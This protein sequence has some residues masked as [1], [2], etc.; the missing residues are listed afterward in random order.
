MAKPSRRRTR[1]SVFLGRNVGTRIP[2]R[3]FKVFCEGE[4][5]ETDYVKALKREPSIHDNTSIQ[6]EIDPDSLGSSPLTLVRAAVKALA[7]ETEVDEVWC[8]FDVEWPKNHPHLKEARS[9]A[10]DHGVNVA[11]SNPSFELWL[12]LHFQDQTAW[13]TTSE[14]TRLRRVL[15]ASTGKGVNWATY[16]PLRAEAD[17][18]ARYLDR[19][20]RRGH[21]AFPEGQ[22]VIGYVPIPGVNRRNAL[23]T[24]H[25]GPVRI[26]NSDPLPARRLPACPERSGRRLSMT[27]GETEAPGGHRRAE[28]IRFTSFGSARPE[29]AL[30]TWPTRK[31]R[32]FFSPDR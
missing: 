23:L 15:D 21:H 18:R 2:R 13:L 10:R 20:A 3:T 19:K 27:S 16:M 6:I 28:R 1:G 30:I 7:E 9:L 4:R 12:V 8:L 11:V 14:A 25:P 22:P 17:R 29:V 31:P 32:T 5:T 24:A 26:H